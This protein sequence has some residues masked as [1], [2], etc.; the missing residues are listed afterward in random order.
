[1]NKQEFEK[2]K[3]QKCMSFYNHS[4]ILMMEDGSIYEI[5][6]RSIN[7]TSEA[8]RHKLIKLPLQSTIIFDDFYELSLCFN[9]ETV[10]VILL[11]D[12]TLE[13]DY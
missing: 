8:I 9:S 13:W 11:P 4:N 3:N 5:I 1:M 12:G 10:P 2:F 7:F 6:K